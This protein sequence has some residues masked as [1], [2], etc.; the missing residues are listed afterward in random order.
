M[1]GKGAFVKDLQGK[2][3]KDLIEMRRKMTKDLHELQMKHAMRAVQKTHEITKLSKDIAR[4]STFLTLKIKENYGG[5]M[6]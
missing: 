6:K 5:N 4:V 2:S 1:K 3:I